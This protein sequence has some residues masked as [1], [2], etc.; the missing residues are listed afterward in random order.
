MFRPDAHLLRLLIICLAC[1]VGALSAL[2]DADLPSK[3]PPA[4]PPPVPATIRVLRGEKVEIP[5]GIYGSHKGP[6]RFLVRGKPEHG[7]LT[8]PVR[9][10][11]ETASVT[12]AAPTNIG[13]AQDRFFYSAQNPTGVSS[14]VEVKIIIVDPPPLLEAPTVLD[15]PAILTG[16]TASRTLRLV[17]KGGGFAEGELQVEGPWELDGPATY[18]IGAGASQSFTLIFRPERAGKASGDIIYSSNREHSTLLGGQAEDPVAIDPPSVTVQNQPGEAIR[19]GLFHVINHTDADIPLRI[20]A[21]E[22]FV[23]PTSATAPAQ[24]DV[25]VNLEIKADD[26]TVLHDEVHIVAG[27]RE[28]VVPVNGPAPGPLLH[29]VL[30]GESRQDAK[31]GR[32]AQVSIENLGGTGG[33]WT[34]RIAPPFQVSA[35]SCQLM[36]GRKQVVEVTLPS[37]E[38][39]RFRAFLEISGEGQST[40]IPIDFAA[41]PP[42][43]SAPSRPAGPPSLS[44]LASA[45]AAASA[46]L[47]MAIP[48]I[49]PSLATAEPA[50][51]DVREFPL[52]DTSSMLPVLRRSVTATPTSASIAIPK[53]AANAGGG[54][55]I[56]ERVLSL[57]KEHDL[58]VNW[59]ERRPTKSQ[60]EGKNTVLQLQ[61]LKP[62][63]YYRLRFSP[64]DAKGVVD[65]PR[66]V[67]E[68]FTPAAPHRSISGPWLWVV[69][70]AAFVVGTYFLQ[71]RR[72]A[73]T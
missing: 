5:L 2:A 72:R 63:T 3:L 58:Q 28:I 19:H 45:P 4:P 27:G 23:F 66:F 67:A 53:D 29:A 15:F 60:E 16:A 34:C 51:Q 8:G 50:N 25:V 70:A 17:N 64:R 71:R 24:G 40:E 52:L 48:G 54:Y 57:G 42:A 35:D 9:T 22:R 14:P 18:H 62:A 32:M 46:A 47:A 21:G 1:G 31:N 55:K 38:T 68:F 44:H 11:L 26:L 49:E 10:G 41:A 7:Q 6:I 39:G 30:A 56:E 73:R 37:S 13:I 36:P 61:G 43:R 59:A 20:A 33:V 12:Y 65:E 69:L